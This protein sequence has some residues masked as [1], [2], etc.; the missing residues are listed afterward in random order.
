[1]STALRRA[2]YSY[3][4]NEGSS[5]Q[6]V[7]GWKSRQ[8]SF[9]MC[10]DSNNSCNTNLFHISESRPNASSACGGEAMS[11]SSMPDPTSQHPPA[12]MGKI[13]TESVLRG[14]I[15]FLGLQHFPQQVVGRSPSSCKTK[16]SGT[17][18]VAVANG[19]SFSP[20]SGSTSAFGE[21]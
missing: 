16:P 21:T 12:F 3:F 20:F 4:W 11:S 2:I 9:L 13:A 1:M 19:T 18:S 7:T 10:C 6:H 5:G 14:R 17:T 15:I 8:K